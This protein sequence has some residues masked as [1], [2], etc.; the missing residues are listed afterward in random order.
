VS[1]T[2]E[3]QSTAAGA[4]REV[5]GADP[6]AEDHE[7]P[8]CEFRPGRVRQLGGGGGPQE[9]GDGFAPASPALGPVG[10]GQ[11]GVHLSEPIPTLIYNATPGPPS[12]SN[13]SLPVFP[14]LFKL[15]GV[16]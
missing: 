8:E 7:Q 2:E 5:G 13:T 12:R 10:Q 14:W 6:Q 11:A 3:H 9:D 15:T 4:E 1:A 16:G